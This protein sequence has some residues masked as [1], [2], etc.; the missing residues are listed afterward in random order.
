MI[1]LYICHAA[2]PI[3]SPSLCLLS[4]FLANNGNGRFPVLSRLF[5]APAECYPAFGDC[6]LWVWI[7]GRYGRLTA[8]QCALNQRTAE[9]G[10]E[11]VCYGEIQSTGCGPPADET[12]QSGGNW[13]LCCVAAELYTARCSHHQILHNCSTRLRSLLVS[14]IA[15][16]VADIHI[17]IYIRYTSQVTYGNPTNSTVIRR[18]FPWKPALKLA[19]RIRHLCGS[20]VVNPRIVCSESA[21]HLCWVHGTVFWIMQSSY[22]G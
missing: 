20:S 19:E 22:P 5:C 11:R 3:V 6:E 21:E 17:Y 16:R 18:G 8:G 9:C 14:A 1:E 13:R 12:L 10:R 4:H 15:V 7:C 2:W